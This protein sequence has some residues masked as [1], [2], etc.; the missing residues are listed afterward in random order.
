MK[1]LILTSLLVI[2]GVN[3]ANS[4]EVNIKDGKVF[5]DN[6]AILKY[7][8]IN[9][10]QSSFYTLSDDE[11]LMYKWS[12]NETSQNTD[13]DFL[14]LNFLT[15]KKKIQTTDYS[16]IASMSSKKSMEKL[17][18]WLLKEKVLD[19]NGNINSEKL[20]IFFE[21]YDEKILERTTR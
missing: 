5:L 7:E 20:E 2:S 19:S 16:Q 10:W 6:N 12:D 3:F 13:D 4:Q 14:T 21:K 1:K 9:N 8:K 17:I 18:K 15:L 11:I